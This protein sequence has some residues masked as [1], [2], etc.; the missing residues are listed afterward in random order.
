[1][2]TA[3]KSLPA[4]ESTDWTNFCTLLSTRFG[5]IDPDAEFWAQ[6]ENLK[7]GS[8]TAA[9]YVHK[10]GYC[11]KGITVLPLSNGDKIHSFMTGLNSRVKEKVV[12]ALYGMGDGSGKWMD[13]DQLM[14][15]T[16]KRCS[17]EA[18]CRLLLLLLLLPL[19]VRSAPLT[20]AMPVAVA[21]GKDRKDRRNILLAM[22]RRN[23]V[24]RGGQPLTVL[25]QSGS[26]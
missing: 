8:L 6:L 19:S 7:Q 18:L 17:M 11:F 2:Q 24:G 22:V 10:M 1:M 9:P 14:Q 12:T 4:A 5:Q 21:R 20:E 25:Q 13:P 23:P 26:G 15:C 3:L 16:H